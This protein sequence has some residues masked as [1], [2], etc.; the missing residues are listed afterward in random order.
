MKKLIL[1]TVLLGFI[2][3]PALAS[4]TLDGVSPHL[5]WWPVGHPTS[6]HQYWDFTVNVKDDG[7]PWEYYAEPPT[8]MDNPSFAKAWIS[9]VFDGTTKDAQGFYTDGGS[10]TGAPVTGVIDVQLQIE[11]FPVNPYKEIWVDIGFEGT[12]TNANGSGTGGGLTY[13]TIDLPPFGDPYGVAELGFRIFPNPSKEDI[14]FTIERWE[15]PAKLEWI[16]VDTICTPEPATIAMLGL[17]S[18]ALLR[19]RRIV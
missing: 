1:I 17:G 16:H 15:V 13:N 5:G 12:L 6:T 8:E 3:A 4:P 7:G 9:G 18:L 11:N 10:F 19:K 2:A 14:F